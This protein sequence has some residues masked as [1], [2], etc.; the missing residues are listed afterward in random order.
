MSLCSAGRSVRTCTCVRRGHL[1]EQVGAR[2][3]VSVG[4]GRGRT[5]RR[6]TGPGCLGEEVCPALAP[7][8]PASPPRPPPSV[9]GATCWPQAHK[10]L[11]DPKP[12]QPWVGGL[13]LQPPWTQTPGWRRTHNGPGGGREPPGRDGSLQTKRSG[14]RGGR[15][16]A[17]APTERWWPEHS[18][19]HDT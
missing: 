11:P 17:A 3:Q 13:S 12:Q 14:L 16:Q 19:K 6:A 7:S 2:V 8:C 15:P 10:P 4:T 1:Q 9:S 5:C 18:G